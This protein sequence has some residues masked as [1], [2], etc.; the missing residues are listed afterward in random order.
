MDATENARAVVTR[1]TDAWLADDLDGIL[2]CYAEEFTLHYFG[3]NAFT[4]AHRGKD[5]AI[6]T[7]LAVGARA[8]RRL[9]AVEEILSGPDAA[10]AVV[11]ERLE[12]EGEAH[13]V[14]RVLR[15]RIAGARLAE[16]WLYD[17][18]QDLIDRAW[19]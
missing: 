7:L 8:P 1:Y 11:R 16:C 4:G 3:D 17:E 13:D 6:A 15:F 12:I 5:A 2:D 18:R 9:L 14:R 19:A 10:V